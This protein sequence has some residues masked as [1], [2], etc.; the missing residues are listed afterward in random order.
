M[1]RNFYLIFI[2]P[3]IIFLCSLMSCRRND[4]SDIE[5]MSCRD[6]YAEGTSFLR[7]KEVP[8]SALLYFSAL[9]NRL[10]PEMTVEEKTLCGKALN[11]LGYL[12]FHYYGNIPY[13][14]ESLVNAK[15]IAL[16]TNDKKLLGQTSLNTAI[17]N[18]ICY[19]LGLTSRGEEMFIQN[20]CD[21]FDNALESG[22]GIT[23][24]N[25]FANMSTELGPEFMPPEFVKR[26]NI[27]ASLHPAPQDTV[28]GTEFFNERLRTS[29]AIIN[30]NLDEAL[31]L[32]HGQ[33]ANL[34][35]V[36]DS[37]RV[38]A[39]IYQE[40]ARIYKRS[41]NTDS[42]YIYL[43]KTLDVA[44][45][46]R[47]FYDLAVTSKSLHDLALQSGNLHDADKWLIE[48]Y[49]MRDSAIVENNLM[50]PDN[51][52]MVSNIKYQNK[53]YSYQLAKQRRQLMIAAFFVILLL[54]TI[55][56]LVM[57]FNKNRKLRESH[58]ELYERYKD[59][60][61]QAIPEQVPGAAAQSPAEPPAPVQTSADKQKRIDMIDADS[62]ELLRQRVEKII[63]ESD[64]V[65]SPDFS[66]DRLAELADS[67]PRVISYV[68]NETMGKT[69]YTLLNERR[70]REACQR[71]EDDAN[72]GHLTI[73]GISRSLGYKSRT[74][75]VTV[76]KKITGLTPSEFQRAARKS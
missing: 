25:C 69:F 73:E 46:D 44:K 14:F 33:L 52:E 42:A 23:A 47:N 22:D 64:E 27:L 41:G 1:N 39:Q 48:Y 12:Y 18:I 36:F 7:G 16:E 38:K 74:T 31:I 61:K 72:Y 43:H 51:L 24:L 63:E 28:N 71:L 57:L 19:N 32:L 40:L 65:F 9:A 53:D 20:L 70:V 6:L 68:I 5:S 8:D 59:S 34:N 26:I 76:F 13:A 75:L 62:S 67:K 37:E 56:L 49:N 17:V 54:I 3:L 2:L 15:Q 21:G 30:G 35:D 60:L 66:L 55:P 45:T 58:R 50:T 29:Q 10:S 4:K 11:R